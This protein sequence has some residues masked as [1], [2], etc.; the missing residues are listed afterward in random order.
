MRNFEKVS[1]NQKERNINTI[2]ISL[3]ATVGLIGL[4][5]MIV[6]LSVGNY[7]FSIWYLIAF[8]LALVYVVIRINA[9]FPIY[10]SIDNDK[11]IMSTWY[12]EIMPYKLPEKTTFFS[13][14][15]PDTIKTE[16]I[17]IKDIMSIYIGSERLFFKELPEDM[18]P[19]SLKRA[20][21]DEHIQNEVKR[22]DFMLVVAK[23]GEECFM[24]V[25]NFDI[26]ELAK[27]LDRIERNG[28]K[29][30]IITNNPK[31]SKIREDS[32]KA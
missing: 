23:D 4:V 27:L 13:D 15:I 11:L 8:L 32:K 21:E 10:V 25:D 19:I 28:D 18:I 6:S 20:L 16:E 14:F 2:K 30:Q 26:K 24:S 7:L 5:M 31:L 12:N 22:M 17:M 29:V 1:L 3:V 9:V